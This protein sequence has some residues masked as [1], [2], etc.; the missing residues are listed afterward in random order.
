MPNRPRTKTGRQLVLKLCQEACQ[1][2][3]LL[4]VDTDEVLAYWFK[5]HG[6]LLLSKVISHVG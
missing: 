5:P 6:I 2:E 1:G 4:K 3:R